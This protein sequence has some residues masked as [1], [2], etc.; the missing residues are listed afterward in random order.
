MAE[1]SEAEARTE[2]VKSLRSIAVC[3]QIQTF[4]LLREHSTMNVD[5]EH[6]HMENFETELMRCLV[7]PLEGD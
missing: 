1:Y 7:G 2:N 6:M 4:I 3:Q 5:T